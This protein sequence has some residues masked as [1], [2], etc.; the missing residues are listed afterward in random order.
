MTTR[1]HLR[2]LAQGF[3]LLELLVVIGIIAILAG[4]LLPALGRAKEKGRRISCLNNLKQIALAMHVFVNDN[5]RYPWR[6]PE[7][8]G[9]S[10]G[11]QRVY[12]TF[13]VLR[14]ELSSPQIVTCPSDRREVAARWESLVDTNV[15]YFVGVD[16]KEGRS[17]M[18]LVGDA[19][20][21]GGR[22]NRDCPIAGVNN[23][24]MEFTK[25]DIPNLFWHGKPHGGVGNVSIG[26]ASAHQ[27]NARA[28]REILL[29][30]G[31]DSTAFNNHILAPR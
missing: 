18:L 17:G 24:A 13:R 15:S 6:I 23:H 10:K 30:S 9:G 1:T 22:K 5:E 14:N 31:D 19:S 21:D 20:L 12:W 26:D 29:T 2:R 4:L 28:T 25:K 27:V 11:R 3:T 16:I 8:D 7:D